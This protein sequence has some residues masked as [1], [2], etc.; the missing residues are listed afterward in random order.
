M[1]VRRAPTYPPKTGPTPQKSCLSE[2]FLKFSNSVI[3]NPS[4]KSLKAAF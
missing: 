3:K 2:I 4:L 1:L